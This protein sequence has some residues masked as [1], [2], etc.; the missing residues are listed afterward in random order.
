M[1]KPRRPAEEG[2]EAAAGVAAERPANGSVARCSC[3][4]QFGSISDDQRMKGRRIPHD[5]RRVP[6][7]ELERK[8]SAG[9]RHGKLLALRSLLVAVGPR[10]QA[11]F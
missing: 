6:R 7:S 4:S 2:V 10:L 11:S 5:H 3:S 9:H 1:L 8:L